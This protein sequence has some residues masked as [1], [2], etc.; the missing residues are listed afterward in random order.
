[1]ANAASA[2]E[3]L[4]AESEPQD[5]LLRH[6]AAV[7]ENLKMLLALKEALAEED[8]SEAAMYWS[9]APQQLQDDLWLATTAGGIFTTKERAQLKSSE[10]T[11]A[12]IAYKS[13]ESQS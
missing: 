9:E 5:R 13:K 2:Y 6:N 11:Q 7:R 3:F 4:N 1:M 10:M 12:V 8:F